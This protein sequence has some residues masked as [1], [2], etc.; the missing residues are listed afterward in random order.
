MTYPLVL[1]PGTR[2]T[3][4]Y[5]ER[6]TARRWR[7]ILLNEDEHVVLGG[8][9]RKM[10]AR[11]LGF[12]VVEV[13]MVPLETDAEGETLSWPSD[14]L[15]MVEVCFSPDWDPFISASTGLAPD[16]VSEIEDQLD[17]SFDEPLRCFLEHGAGDFLFRVH[18]IE[19]ETEDGR[20]TA[21]AYWDLTFVAYRPFSEPPA[22]PEPADDDGP[23]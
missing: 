5:R 14:A 10:V 11:D 17:P 18:Y 13:S 2:L 19:A 1:A 23:F 12:G 6:M 22:E 15:R 16:S 21:P 9:V 8:R 20:I 7:Q 3:E 4:E